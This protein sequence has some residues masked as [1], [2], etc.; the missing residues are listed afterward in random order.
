M[1]PAG[2]VTILMVGVGTAGGASALLWSRR[3]RKNS[4]PS[5][6][7]AGPPTASFK[8]WVAAIES[9]EEALRATGNSPF[10]HVELNTSTSSKRFPH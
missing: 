8:E 5:A 3:R 1:C 7:N 10:V 9:L 2:L 6:A 4:K